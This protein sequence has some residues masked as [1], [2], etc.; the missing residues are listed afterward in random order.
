MADRAMRET[1]DAR[2]RI[3]LREG[4][5]LRDEGEALV[6]RLG[7]QQALRRQ[8]ARA[9]RGGLEPVC[10]QQVQRAQV[11]AR[12]VVRLRQAVHV[13][14]IAWARGRARGMARLVR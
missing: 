11:L 9:H 7:V 1:T 5:A 8:V 13:V 4:H 6:V 12:V 2:V 10:A 3:R 14:R